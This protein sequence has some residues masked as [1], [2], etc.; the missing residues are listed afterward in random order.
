M[1]FYLVI[2]KTTNGCNITDKSKKNAEAKRPYTIE[3]ILY[4]SIDM[5]F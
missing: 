2:E 1:A 4:D 5:K 3:S